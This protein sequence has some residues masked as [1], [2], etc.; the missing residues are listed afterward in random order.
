MSSTNQFPNLFH[1]DKWQAQFSN[2]PSI[3]SYRDMRIYDN[4]VKS[5]VLPDY[6]MDVI[7]SDFQGFRIMHPDGG[8]KANYDLSQL[9]VEFK[10]SEDMLN[11]IYL[12][13]FMKALKYGDTTGF[14]N[15]DEIF[16]KNTIKA[17]TINILDNQ[18]RNIADWKFTNAFLIS[19][20]SLSL[21]MGSSE[22]ITF[23]CNFAYQEIKYETKSVK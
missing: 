1:S 23:A 19:M 13:E 9:Q 15:P 2:L 11:Y 17:I 20:S 10:V 12:F 8:F 5:I 14:E 3:A 16:R 6:N 18:K 4:Y 7:Y 21:E 22:E